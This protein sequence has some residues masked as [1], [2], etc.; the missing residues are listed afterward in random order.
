MCSCARGC[1]VLTR[2]TTAFQA[3]LQDGIWNG[4]QALQHG[5]CARDTGLALS[6]RPGGA[7]GAAGGRVAAGRAGGH[8]QHAQRRAR[9]LQRQA[10]D[11]RSARR[12]AARRLRAGRRVRARGRARRP[13]AQPGAAGI[14]NPNHA[15]A[16]AML[17]CCESASMHGAASSPAPC[18]RGLPTHGEGPVGASAP[19]RTHAVP[20]LGRPS[21]ARPQPPGR[22]ARRW[23][24]CRCV[25]GRRS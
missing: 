7:A 4:S 24:R 20:S 12:A 19:A 16:H 5:R 23:R 10:A 21:R 8:G 13:A 1:M 17:Y 15:Q 18:L 11:V 22:A 25:C 2:H 3:G 9:A 6:R 14:P